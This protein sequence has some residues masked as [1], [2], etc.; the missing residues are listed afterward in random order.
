MNSV[1]NSL[2]LQQPMSYLWLDFSYTNFSRVDA[3]TRSV[4]AIRVASNATLI[5]TKPNVRHVI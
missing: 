3:N 5:T 4:A 2:V 1:N